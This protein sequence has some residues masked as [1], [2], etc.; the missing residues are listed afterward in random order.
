VSADTA[1]ERDVNQSGPFTRQRRILTWL[2]FKSKTEI[3]QLPS[4]R[5]H[6]DDEMIDLALIVQ[7]SVSNSRKIVT[8]IPAV[9]Q[10][11]RFLL[12]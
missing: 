8:D 11:G 5:L 1:N 12:K 10:D 9:L 6:V 3:P 7:A 4:I 2:R